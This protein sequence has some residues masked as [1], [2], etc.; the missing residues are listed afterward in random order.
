MARLF[1]AKNR[2]VPMGLA[3]TAVQDYRLLLIPGDADA[4]CID[5]TGQPAANRSQQNG[6]DA[7]RWRKGDIRRPAREFK[8]AV[9][10]QSRLLHQLPGEVRVVGSLHAPEPEPFFLLLQK[11]QGLFQ[12]RHRAVKRGSEE[13][14]GQ[15]PGFARE[16]GSD[17]NAILPV[18]IHFDR[19]LVFIAMICFYR[20]LAPPNSLG[21]ALLNHLARK[22]KDSPKSNFRL[23]RVL[24]A[25][26]QPR[27]E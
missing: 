13:I 21:V 12:F 26:E 1:C 24:S 11:L 7:L 18:L 8:P 3:R 2:R 4:S 9:H 10:A 16:Y 15:G 20:H 5:R 19:A 27:W 17:P 14:Y 6:R 25:H 23:Y 22:I